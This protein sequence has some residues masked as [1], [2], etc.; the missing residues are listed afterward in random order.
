[1]GGSIPEVSSPVLTKPV[2]QRPPTPLDPLARAL[3]RR[4]FDAGFA[5]GAFLAYLLFVYFLHAGLRLVAF[6]G[7][8]HFYMAAAVSLLHGHL[9][10]PRPALGSECFLVHGHCYGYFGITPSL[11][12]L[13]VALFERPPYSAFTEGVFLSLGFLA[14]A[15]GA[16]WCAR[17]LIALWAPR[18]G[19]RGQVLTGACSAAA[20]GASPLL[21]LAG[22]PMVYEEAIL[23]GVACAGL[24][25]GALLSFW[26]D[27]RRRTL[28]ILLVADIAG[29]L[30]RPTVGA[31]GVLGTL[32]VGGWFVR[33][34]RAAGPAPALPALAGL[35]ART[36]RVW[37]ACLM[38][39]AIVAFASAPVVLYLKFGSFSP[40]YQ[41]QVT[42][43]EHPHQLAVYQHAGGLNVAAFPTKVLSALRPDTLQVFSRPPFVRLGDR[44]VTAV[45]P[46]KARDFDWGPTAGLPAVFPFSAALA[47]IGLVAV[48][49]AALR[50][51]RS[52]TPDPGLAITVVVLVSA[53]AAVCLDL[54]FPGQAYRYTADWLP[55][56]F[57]V[58][59]V[60][61]AVAGA[62]LAR[63]SQHRIVAAAAVAS[64]LLASQL[65]IQAGLSVNN[66][67]SIGGERPAGCLE[68]PNPY[69]P[70]RALFC[71][72]TK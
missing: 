27:P 54:V 5:A 72:A 9:W 63:A 15:A 67:L 16:W 11:V 47:V 37:G 36:L 48:G 34:S 14:A 28:V 29:V 68:P 26:G 57:L 24:S 17:Q 62:H 35:P 69:G 45:W 56:A 18:L 23:W 8:N 58:V 10:V 3:Q 33:Q 22:R 64:I 43:S 6:R 44:Y 59:P 41:D 25:L 40:P 51:R 32:V 60:G 70:L 50:W 39:G 65:F 31:C 20:F 46:A 13:P 61:L 7:R 42:L 52:R 12:R 21:F 53:V 4:P 30:A 1:M 55:V 66:S 2:R 19:G 49:R 71:P 38:V